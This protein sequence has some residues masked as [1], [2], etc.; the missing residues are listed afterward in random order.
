MTRDANGSKLLSKRV[1]SCQCKKSGCVKNYCQCFDQKMRCSSSCKCIS[2][3]YISIVFY[4]LLHV[5]NLMRMCFFL[6]IPTDCLN[7]LITSTDCP[8]PAESPMATDKA[9]RVLW[10]DQHVDKES[11]P[12]LVNSQIASASVVEPVEENRTHTM[13]RMVAMDVLKTTMDGLEEVADI[14][15]AQKYD[16][17]AT[18]M[19]IVEKFVSMAKEILKGDFEDDA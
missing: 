4:L 2:N 19:T 10:N 18:E 15:M 14:C 5:P 8:S 13:F 11:T 17:M 12:K 3:L 16:S 1:G 9:E 6:S 7:K